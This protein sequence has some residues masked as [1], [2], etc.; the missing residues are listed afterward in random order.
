MRKGT[1]RRPLRREPAL[2]SALARG[3]AVLR[4]FESGNVPLT[5]AELARLTK[6]PKPTV[7]RLTAT[8]VAAGL[9]AKDPA[10]E[11]Y[12][13][14]AGVLP[15]AHAFLSGLDVRAQSRATMAALAEQTGATVYLGVRSGLE[16]VIIE[17]CQPRAPVLLPRLA[18]GSR[19]ALATSALGRAYLA[20]LPAERREALERELAAAQGADWPA[21]QR[22]LRQSLAE[23]ATTGVC[24]SLGELY[25]DIHSVATAILRPDGEPVAL[26]CGGAAHTFTEARLR[27]EVR[28]RLLAAAAEIARSIGGRTLAQN[29]LADLAPSV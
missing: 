17:T 16:M 13:L 4:C 20:A 1:P 3:L 15:L 26:V 25:A 23:A 6:I 11:T 2:V 24:L 5:N 8:L 14:A 27:S 22:A 10:R 28:P 19:I 29:A 12:A 7:S 18:V 21:T 9:L